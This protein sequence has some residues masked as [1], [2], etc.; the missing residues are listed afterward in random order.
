[1]ISNINWAKQF[2]LLESSAV[3]DIERLWANL[4]R[5]DRRQNQTLV[6]FRR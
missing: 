3:T 6:S 2:G 5:L 4:Q 1:M